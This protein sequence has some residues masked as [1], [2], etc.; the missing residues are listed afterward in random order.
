MKDF[1]LPTYTE[2]DYKRVVNKLDPAGNRACNNNLLWAMGNGTFSG[3][4]YGTSLKRSHL[5]NV[6][7]DNAVFDHTSLAGSEIINT[8][9]KNSCKVESVYFENSYMADVTF[10]DKLN[11]KNSNFTKCRIKNSHF[12]SNEIRGSFFSDSELNDCTFDDCLIRSTMFEN[13]KLNRCNLI[14]CNMRN[15]NIEFC[16]I[17]NSNLDGTTISF[18]QFPYIIGI[19]SDSNKIENIYVGRNK[20]EKLSMDEY[21]EEINDCIIYFAYIEEY[22]PLVNL[23]YRIGEKDN[24]RK[25]IF[26]GI[27]K[28]LE[29][30]E[31]RLVDHFCSLG[32]SY[33]LLKVGDLKS[34]LE[35]VDKHIYLNKNNEFF[36]VMI[37]QS[38]NLKASILND[39]TKSMLEIT[40]NTNIDS[41]EYDDA[42]SLCHDIDSIIT[43]ISSDVSSTFQISHNSPYEIVLTCI[44]LTADLIAISELIYKYISMR[45]ANAVVKERVTEYIKKSNAL[46]IDNLS[47]QFDDFEHLLRKSKKNEQSAV[48]TAF[49]G[50]IIESVTNQIQNDLSII[51][52]QSD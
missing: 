25:C 12:I 20:N 42:S 5:R 50:K 3:N 13:A 21:I 49:R 19:F 40:I 47:S 26:G 18:F 46:F 31:L 28:A 48:I 51:V 9:F 45:S 4:Y 41:R 15:L 17:Y 24:A 8:V 1:S 43:I 30:N 37:S 27:S 2:S 36:D 52:A 11:I 16:K 32:K 23:Y 10:D 34:I 14:N 35:Q 38:S 7:F 44:G 29:A 22:F 6:I 33:S 39:T